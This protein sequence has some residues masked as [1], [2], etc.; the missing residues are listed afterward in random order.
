MIHKE[1]VVMRRDN[2]ARVILWGFRS[3]EEGNRIREGHEGRD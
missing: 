3:E 2:P 1:R